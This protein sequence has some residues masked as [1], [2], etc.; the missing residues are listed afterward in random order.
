MGKVENAC[1]TNLVLM[2]TEDKSPFADAVEMK[3]VSDG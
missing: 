1:V 2:K 3:T